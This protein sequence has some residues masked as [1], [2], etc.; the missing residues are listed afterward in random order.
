MR[1]LH[2]VGPREYTASLT[3]LAAAFAQAQTPVEDEGQVR[4]NFT[5][6]E[7]RPKL[8]HTPNAELFVPTVT[9]TKSVEF[10][11]APGDVLVIKRHGSGPIIGAELSFTVEATMKHEYKKDCKTKVDYHPKRFPKNV[12]LELQFG[13]QSVYAKVEYVQKNVIMMT[14]NVPATGLV[15]RIQ[16]PGLVRLSL[17]CD[18]KEVLL[19]GSRVLTPEEIGKYVEP[20]VAKLHREHPTWLNPRYLPE[21]LRVTPGNIADLQLT[22]TLQRV[23]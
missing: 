17:Q 9:P 12:P 5:G 14:E 1:L 15:R 22:A 7:G 23:R 4:F 10:D 11:V 2:I 8:L 21:S 16:R 6:G 19:A 18:N 13:S 20:E 3:I